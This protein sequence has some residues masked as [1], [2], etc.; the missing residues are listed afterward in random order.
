MAREKITRCSVL[1]SRNWD[2][3]VRRVHAARE[4]SRRDRCG[5]KKTRR[6]R[7]F[8]MALR[9]TGPQNTCPW[10]MSGWFYHQTCPKKLMPGKYAQKIYAREMFPNYTCPR[11]MPHS[12]M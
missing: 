11:D 9:K 1:G 3:A 4:T 10:D 6:G 12:R 5:I 2:G 8:H 7:V